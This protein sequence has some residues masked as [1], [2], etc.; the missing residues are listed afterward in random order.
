MN[1]LPFLD[2]ACVIGPYANPGSPPGYE[3]NVEGLVR[4]MDELG[5]AEACP[6]SVTASFYGVDD[7]NRELLKAIEPYPQLH[8]AWLVAP[9]HTGEMPS[10]EELTARM[11]RGSIGLAKMFVDEIQFFTPLL[12]LDLFGE[13]F[14]ALAAG[15][16]P[17][18]LDYANFTH[19]HTFSL[20][21]LLARWPGLPVLLK[22]PKVAH[23]ERVL[24]YLWEKYDNLHVVLSGYQ[25]LGGIEKAVERFGARAFV[26]GSN[27]PY[28]TPLQS[29]LHL[30]YC[31]LS[32]ED[33]R[34]IAGD[35]VRGL[36]RKE[37][38]A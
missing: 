3:G 1:Q 20:R 4:K 29:M 32:E 18:L 33:K 9:D 11:A 7:G 2:V 23:E 8:P 25:L 38:T 34:L 13:V 24:Y 16:T 36:L 14:E 17:L 28:F 37:V 6:S 21:A 26:F 27:Y 19:E 22:F 30:I 10:A 31:E 12:D 5:I 35:T 15:R